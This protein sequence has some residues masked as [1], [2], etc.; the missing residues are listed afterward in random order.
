MRRSC[1][2]HRILLSKEMIARMYPLTTLKV[3]FHCREEPVEEIILYEEI[4]GIIPEEPSVEVESA[5]VVVSPSRRKTP[6]RSKVLPPTETTKETKFPLKKVK[7]ESISPKVVPQYSEEEI[8]KRPAVCS[9]CGTRFVRYDYLV[10]HMRRHTGERPFQCKFCGKSFPRTTDLNVHERY[11]TN[12]NSHYCSVCNKGFNRPYNLKVHM[13]VHTQAR[14]FKC[15]DCPKLYRQSNDLKTHI[16]KHTGE[17]SVCDV[18]G[19]SFLLKHRLTQHKKTKHNIEVV[20]HIGRLE[21]F[22]EQ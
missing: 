1:C 5:P 14:P 6:R 20:S 19:E 15:P 11:H 22:E 8:A 18:C 7:P 21:K 4:I 16:R 10:V 9:I 17:R 13:R 12:Q 3:S 2:L